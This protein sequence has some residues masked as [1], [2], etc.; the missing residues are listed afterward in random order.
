[1]MREG[2]S[3]FAG[4]KK[5]NFFKCPSSGTSS[6]IFPQELL[7]ASFHKD[8]LLGPTFC[9]PQN[10]SVWIAVLFFWFCYKSNLCNSAN[11]K[12]EWNYGARL[13]MLPDELILRRFLSNYKTTKH[14]RIYLYTAKKNNNNMTSGR[15]LR[16][17]R[18]WAFFCTRGIK[19]HFWKCWGW[20]WDVLTC[21]AW[22]ALW[23][24]I[25]FK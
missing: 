6:S 9:L 13:L 23:R 14:T 18:F 3:V 17:R 15:V 2:K 25:A 8:K 20:C 10:Y 19:L 12:P 4:Y 1:M 7:Q 24:T 21:R 11:T 16:P 5:V 22:Q